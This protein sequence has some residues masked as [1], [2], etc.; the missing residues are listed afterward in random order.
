MAISRVIITGANGAGK[1]WFAGTLA[2]RRQDIKIISYD[3]VR[4]TQN[5]VKR[6][7]EAVAQTMSDITG[8]DHW[9]VE[10]GPSLLYHA[11]DRAQGVV[12]LDPYPW[13]RAGRLAR[14]PWLNLGRT[15]SEL[16][17]GNVDWPIQQYRFALRS[18]AKGRQ[19]RAAITADLRR[20]PPQVLW[21][22]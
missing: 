20:T 12:W 18:L 8:R 11:L 3:A 1:S 13:T 6:P 10:G 14:R 2:A 21:H 17:D 22:C 19:M 9:V 15:R 7:D 4:L 5:W 16:P